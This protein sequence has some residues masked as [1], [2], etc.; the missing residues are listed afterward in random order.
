MSINHAG[1]SSHCNSSGAEKRFNPGSNPCH[2]SI[3]LSGLSSPRADTQTGGV[4]SE[5]QPAH[6]K[7]S[8]RQGFVL[9]V[10]AEDTDGQRSPF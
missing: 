7:R 8:E 2:P 9:C 1:L 6:G 5:T 3:L 10:K 4:S